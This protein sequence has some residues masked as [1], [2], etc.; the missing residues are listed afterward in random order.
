ML[1]L[2]ARLSTLPRDLERPALVLHIAFDSRVIKLV[3]DETLGI[4]DSVFRVGVAGVLR[5]VTNQP[6]FVGGDP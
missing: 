5:S 4:K 6:F 2:D 1:D 3:A